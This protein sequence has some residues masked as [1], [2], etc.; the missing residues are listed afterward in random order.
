[1]GRDR[2][3]DPYSWA[4]TGVWEGSPEQSKI[5][6]AIMADQAERLENE[7]EFTH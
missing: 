3:G 6:A 2:G 5:T 1:M 7:N 4:T